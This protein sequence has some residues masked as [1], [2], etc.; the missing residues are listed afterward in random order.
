VYIGRHVFIG[1]AQLIEIQSDCV[2]SDRVSIF[3]NSHGFSPDGPNIMKQDLQDIHPV[4]IREG[5]FIG[6]N[7]CIFAGVTLGRHCVVG[8]S[9]V[10][11]KSFPDYSMVAGNPA[12]LIKSY[13][14]ETKKWERAL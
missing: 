8:A 4:C 9:S 7:S 14:L 13:N 10:V 6:L 1:A 11:T 12:K 3:D 2:L 5:S